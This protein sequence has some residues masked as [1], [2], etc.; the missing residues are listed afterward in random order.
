MTAAQ[1]WDAH[2]DAVLATIGDTPD[3]TDYYQGRH[4]GRRGVLTDGARE[5]Q[6]RVAAQRADAAVVVLAATDGLAASRE[7]Y[8]RL[9]RAGA[10]STSAVAV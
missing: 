5:A 9:L 4:A 3:P 10:L 1:T 7:L 2:I 8:A 6:A